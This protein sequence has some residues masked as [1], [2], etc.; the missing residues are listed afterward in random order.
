MVNERLRRAMHRAGHDVG[1]LATAAEV[2]TKS[3]ER[4]LG[5]AVPYPRTRYRVAAALQVDES[6]L[7]PSESN[8]ASLTGAELV[9]TYPRRGDVPRDLWIELLRGA[10]RNVDLLAFAGL[11]LT[12]EHPDWLPM[13]AAKARA[14]TRVRLL[15]GDPDGA[16]LAARD[17]EYR[18][19]G[20]VAG[21]VA[22]VLAYYGER[23]PEQVEIRL[24]DTPLYNSIYRFD[25]DMVVN[26]HA[27]GVLA[28]FTPTMHIRRIDGAYFNT[29]SESYERV[30]ASA[31]SADDV[32]GRTNGPGDPQD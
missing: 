31:R 6:Y 24:H 7:W 29:Y 8:L 17:E 21:R 16:Q 27:Y 14:G 30:W 18:I 32:F 26:V 12:E 28:A 20:G 5:G 25:D 1:T 19:G 11:F 9:A 13:L 22:A 4:W 10:E 3:V 2:S 23:M 15:I